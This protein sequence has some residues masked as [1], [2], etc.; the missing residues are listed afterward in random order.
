MSEIAFLGTPPPTPSCHLP[1]V[2]TLS[3]RTET[4]SPV[5][6]QFLPGTH[7][8][9]RTFWAGSIIQNC[10]VNIITSIWEPRPGAIRQLECFLEK[11]ASLSLW[12]LPWFP[13]DL[14]FPQQARFRLKQE[15]AILGSL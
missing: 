3:F 12:H 6:P 2:S 8:Q 4:L 9:A 5:G 7:L 10:S 1:P 14:T 15:N 11:P 13:L